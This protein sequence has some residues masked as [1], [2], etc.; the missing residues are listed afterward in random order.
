MAAEPDHTHLTSP[1]PS[2]ARRPLYVP[3]GLALLHLRSGQCRFPILEDPSVPGGHRF[4]AQAT[5]TDRVYCARHLSIAIA[6]PKSRAGKISIGS[7]KRK[8]AA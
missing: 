1:L 5:S 8:S 6:V 2:A 4:C 3:R 7:Q